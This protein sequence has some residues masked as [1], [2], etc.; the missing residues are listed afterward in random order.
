MKA[1]ELGLNISKDTPEEVSE[2]LRIIADKIDK[3]I[4]VCFYDPVYSMSYP[5]DNDDEE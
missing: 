3:Q 4:Y 1:Y 5:G 2:T